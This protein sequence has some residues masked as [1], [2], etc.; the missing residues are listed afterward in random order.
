MEHYL[1]NAATT[2]VLPCARETA[3]AAMEEFGNPGSLHAKGTAA[4]KMLEA[5]AEQP[6]IRHLT[7]PGES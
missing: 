4:R 1:D 5:V 6:G 3:I 7:M 2:A